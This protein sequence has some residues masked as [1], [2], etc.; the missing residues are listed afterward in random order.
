MP[1][2]LTEDLKAR[3]PDEF[4][5]AQALHDMNAQAP[6]GRRL[7]VKEMG[8]L[9]RMPHAPPVPSAVSAENPPEPSEDPRQRDVC[10]CRFGC[11]SRCQ[12]PCHH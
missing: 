10:S 8:V 9:R 6:G 12:C 7:T 2:W 5:P 4:I 1:A 3:I 11:S